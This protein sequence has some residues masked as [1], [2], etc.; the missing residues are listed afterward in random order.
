MQ[1]IQF[2]HALHR[3]QEILKEFMYDRHL[4]IEA[5]RERKSM[6][7]K[8]WERR[9]RLIRALLAEMLPTSMARRVAPTCTPVCC[10]QV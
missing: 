2:E 1:L 4:A 9:F 10:T 6:L 8:A 7:R 3:Q 5:E